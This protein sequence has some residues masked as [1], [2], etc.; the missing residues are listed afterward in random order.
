MSDRLV[1]AVPIEK[2][3]HVVT[4]EPVARVLAK[5]EPE[6]VSTLVDN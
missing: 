1:E 6:K 3:H 4:S 2:C 5:V